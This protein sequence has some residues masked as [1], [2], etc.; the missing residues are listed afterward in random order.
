MEADLEERVLLVLSGTTLGVFPALGARDLLGGG[1]DGRALGLGGGLGLGLRGRLGFS[2]G[3][4]LLG[5]EGSDA[6]GSCFI[7]LACF[8][9]NDYNKGIAYQHW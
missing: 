8:P 9:E 1:L 5:F 6:A 4:E 2:F 7:A 3:D